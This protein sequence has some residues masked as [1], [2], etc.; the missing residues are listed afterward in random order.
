MT[1]NIG[2]VIGGVGLIGRFHA[3]TLS[4]E[5]EDARLIGVVD[6]NAKVAERVARRP[7]PLHITTTLSCWRIRTWMQW[8]LPCPPRSSRK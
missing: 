6:S 8:W 5:I 4:H 2:G 7:I 1:I 3:L